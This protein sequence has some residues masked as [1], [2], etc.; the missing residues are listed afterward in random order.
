MIHFRSC[1]VAIAC[2]LSAV[3]AAA[4]APTSAWAAV[5]ANDYQV[6]PDITYL[7]ASNWEGK[8]DVYTPRGGRTAS[9]DAHI[10]GGGWTGGSPRVGTSC[11]RCR[12]SRWASRS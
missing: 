9:D 11:V 5:M 8:L 6:T 10:H 2:T 3:S 4:Q 12:I 7:S 1:V